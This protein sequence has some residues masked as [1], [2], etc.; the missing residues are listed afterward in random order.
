MLINTIQILIQVSIVIFYL[1]LISNNRE[2]IKKY[3]GTGIFLAIIIFLFS[4][5][6]TTFNILYLDLS[7]IE[8]QGDTISIA[9]MFSIVFAFIFSLLLILWHTMLYTIAFIEWNK[10]RNPLTNLDNLKRI[11]PWKHIIWAFVFGILA[12]FISIIV[13]K[14]IG[15]EQG[16]L[17]SKYKKIFVKPGASK[18]IVMTVSLFTVICIAIKEELFFR[19]AILAFLIS[20]CRNNN[21]LI[22]F[23]II[24]ISSAWGLMHFHNT[25]LPAI[26]FTQVFILGV[27]F[28]EIAR[29]SSIESVIAA[30]IGLNITGIFY[31]I[32]FFD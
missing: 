20:K 31:L 29:R 30:H 11:L 19:G 23:S 16:A 22:Y 4:L 8:N 10:V 32:I 6:N 2:L 3:W 24:A 15:V 1:V 25:N 14:M 13:F 21:L 28:A 27:C 12:G 18:A 5:P 9:V 7:S 17:I 26:K